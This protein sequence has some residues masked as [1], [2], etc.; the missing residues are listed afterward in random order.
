MSEFGLVNMYRRTAL[1]HIMAILISVFAHGYR[2]KM[3]QVSWSSPR[4][5]TS[6][7]H[8]LN[9]GKWDE[10]KLR[11]KLKL[12]IIQRIWEESVCS[13]EPIE[14]IIDDTISSK[15]K[16][17]SGAAH[18][19]EGA[20]FHYSHLKK[21][22][23]YGH[24]AVGVLLACNGLVFNYDF[25]LYDKTCSKI[26]IVRKI[27][28]GLPV[29][30]RISYFLCDC[31]YSCAEVMDAFL[32]KGF[33]T[34]GAVKTNR[35][36]F[37]C[38]IRIQIQEFAR[39]IRKEDPNISLVTAAGREYYVYRYEGQLN[40]LEDAV[41]LICYP[42][43]AFGDSRALRIFICTDT[44]LSTQE[45]LDRYTHRWQIEVYFR[46]VK[47]KLSVDKCQIRSSVGIQRFW[48]LMSL[49]YFLCLSGAESTSSFQDGYACLQ[50]RIQIERITYI[51]Q[52]GMRREPLDH[53]L[54][55]T[56]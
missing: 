10:R 20:H 42:K 40:K 48:L 44:S 8:F 26:E 53:L 49:A 56:A 31:W 14:C 2:G 18:P 3:A 28:E 21:R 55:L 35:V 41:I 22:Q 45:I 15:T 19:I 12:E 6:I 17:S 30:P 9:D 7:A 23:D 34:I 52:C 11:E 46:Q 32:A 50:K 51:Y 39:Y 27:A 43:E 25:I 37:P 4:H 29:A 36:I 1:T 5:R 24:Q 38:G 47:Q 54:A 13:G 33:Y 16:P